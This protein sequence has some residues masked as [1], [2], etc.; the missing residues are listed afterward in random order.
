[1][2]AQDIILGARVLHVRELKEALAKEREVNA[3]LR[4]ENASL[5]AGIDLAVIAGAELRGMGEG[6]RLEIWDGWNLVLGSE[7][8]ARDRDGLKALALVQIAQDAGLRIWI[9]FDG[10]RESVTDVGRLRVSYTGGVGG[11][12][13]DRFIQAFVRAAAYLGVSGRLSVRTG[14]MGLRREVMRL[15][16]LRSR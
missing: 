10:D 15:L 16:G 4:D 12:R 9:V 8:V 2:N 3:A 5:R 13:A 1:M 7:R 6:E 14:D 11:Q